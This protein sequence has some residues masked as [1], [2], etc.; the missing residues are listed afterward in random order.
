VSTTSSVPQPS[1]SG[2]ARPSAVP[3]PLHA[4]HEPGTYVCN[5]SGN[6]LRVHDTDT[7]RFNTACHAPLQEWTVTKISTDPDLS[8]WQARTLAS[9]FGLNTSF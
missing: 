6:L 7:R 4:L 8:R 9:Q 3:L 2:D 1:V 5:W